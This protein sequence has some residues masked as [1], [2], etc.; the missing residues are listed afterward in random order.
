MIPSARFKRRSRRPPGSSFEVK[1]VVGLGAGLHMVQMEQDA[2]GP[3]FS[4]SVP[5]T[6][7]PTFAPATT[8][9]PS[10]AANPNPTLAVTHRHPH[11]HPRSHLRSCS[12]P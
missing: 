1:S 3:L 2:Y 12:R 4:F 8:P 5:T 10:P 7:A 6:A 11:R 9:V